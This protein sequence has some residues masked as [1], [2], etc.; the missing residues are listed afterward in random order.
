MKLKRPHSDQLLMIKS[1]KLKNKNKNNKKKTSNPAINITEFNMNMS[2][3]QHKDMEMSA[4][5]KYF[6]P[7]MT[8]VKAQFRFTRALLCVLFLIYLFVFHET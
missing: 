2:T 4:T 5:S 8:R 1:F 3:A 6:S 7:C